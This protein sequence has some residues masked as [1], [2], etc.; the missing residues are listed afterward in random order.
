MNIVS[1]KNE[2]MNIM[3]QSVTYFYHSGINFSKKDIVHFPKPKNTLQKK[4]AL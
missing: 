4:V 1:Y 2:T 3:C